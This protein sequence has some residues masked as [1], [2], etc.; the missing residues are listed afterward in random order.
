M[1]PLPGLSGCPD[2]HPHGEPFQAAL[3]RRERS[4]P[5][6]PGGRHRGGVGRG[7]RRLS[8]HRHHRGPGGQR[9]FPPADRGGAYLLRAGRLHPGGLSGADGS[10]PGEPG[11]LPLGRRGE[12]LPELLHRGR[13]RV[14]VYRHHPPF[15]DHPGR[16][17]SL[18]PPDGTGRRIFAVYHLSGH[19]GLSGRPAQPPGGG[20]L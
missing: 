14:D 18:F 10:V 7:Q 17:R 9:A 19:P 16:H 1:R 8:R 12:Q 15:R 13:G 4:G 2:L 5:G 3:R 6:Y 20:L 11:I